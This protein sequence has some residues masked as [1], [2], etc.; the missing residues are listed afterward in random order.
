[1]DMHQ[2]K[3]DAWIADM[4]AWRKEMTAGQEAM[5]AYPER[6]ES[7]EKKSLKQNIKRSQRGP[8]ESWN[9]W[10]R[11]PSRCIAVDGDHGTGDL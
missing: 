9:V 11:S 3:M 4:R 2:E 8:G 1:M 7:P 6:V 5:E 10:S